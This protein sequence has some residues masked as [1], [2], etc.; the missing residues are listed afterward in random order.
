MQV[1]R[2]FRGV[3]QKESG[4]DSSFFF[5]KFYRKT[6]TSNLEGNPTPLLLSWSMDIKQWA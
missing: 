3:G 5:L 2:C 6:N 1:K 4:L